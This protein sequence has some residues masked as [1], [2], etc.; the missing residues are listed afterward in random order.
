MIEIQPIKE[1]ERQAAHAGPAIF[2][3][4]FFVTVGPLVRIAFAEQ[5]DTETPAQPRVAIAMS[6]QDAIELKNI[7]TS[8]LA[9]LE[10]Q[11]PEGQAGS[12]GA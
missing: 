10:E 9:A 6:H 3:N 7:L 11:S 5:W 1:A 8:L 2:T 12:Q 4:R